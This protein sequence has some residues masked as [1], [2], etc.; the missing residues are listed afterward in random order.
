MPNVNNVVEQELISVEKDF[1]Q[2]VVP[3]LVASATSRLDSS[4]IFF[5]NGSKNGTGTGFSVP[6]WWIRTLP[7]S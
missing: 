2:I 7:S 4:S 5:T 6:F 3:R 1:Y